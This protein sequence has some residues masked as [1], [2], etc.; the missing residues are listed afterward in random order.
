MEQ[1]VY[2][3]AALAVS[4]LACWALIPRIFKKPPPPT[5]D[6]LSEALAERTRIALVDAKV[7]Q[8]NYAAEVAKLSARLERLRAE[9]QPAVA[10]HYDELPDGMGERA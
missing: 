8:E 9:K 6:D 4:A 7:Q 2:M 3:L 1:S 10:R 5:A